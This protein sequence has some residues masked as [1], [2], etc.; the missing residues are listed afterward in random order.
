MKRPYPCRIEIMDEDT[1][2][3]VLA[4]LKEVS[5]YVTVVKSAPVAANFSRIQGSIV[6]GTSP[7]RILATTLFKVSPGVL[8][9]EGCRDSVQPPGG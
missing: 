9:G 3:V 7:A 8:A 2:K 1:A 6:Y 5:F 4:H